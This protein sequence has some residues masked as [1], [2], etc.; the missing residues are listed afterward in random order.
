MGRSGSLST[1]T[2]RGVAV[3]V[4]PPL[5]TLTVPKNPQATDATFYVEALNDVTTGSRTTNGTTVDTNTA[6]LL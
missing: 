6:T 2:A 5:P 4:K 1:A 3:L